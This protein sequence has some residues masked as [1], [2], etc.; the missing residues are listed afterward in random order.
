MAGIQTCPIVDAWAQPAMGNASET[1]PEVVRLL[2]Q[3]GTTHLLEKKLSA[4]ETVEA[5]DRAGIQ[6]LMLSAWHRPGRWV[7]H[8]DVVAEM[9]AQ[10]PDRFVGV[11]AVNLENPV[12]AVRELDRAVRELG[13]KGLRVIPWLWN[14][15]PNA[16]LWILKSSSFPH[17]SLSARSIFIW[18]A[19]T[20]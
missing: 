19:K 16:N 1:L 4:A 20:R 5:M 15:P 18:C 11:A 6:T 9:V 2:Q 13:F 12:E 8:N 7:T 10:F 17:P 14:R 3:S